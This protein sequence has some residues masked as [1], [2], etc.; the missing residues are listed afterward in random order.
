MEAWDLGIITPYME[1]VNYFV[2]SLGALTQ[3]NEEFVN[4]I[5]IDTVDAFQGREK[6][7]IFFSCVRANEEFSIGFLA[8]KRRV[9]VALTRARH[10]LVVVG[11]APTFARNEVWTG[12]IEY[13]KERNALVLS[14]LGAW[15]TAGFTRDPASHASEAE[16]DGD[17][18]LA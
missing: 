18:D 8:D 6:E 16:A 13:C 9:N 12:F 14:P 15:T 3:R 11:N 17:D 5:E 4:N 10:G 7:F 2:D 1:Q